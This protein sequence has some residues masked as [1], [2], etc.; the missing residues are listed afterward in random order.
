MNNIERRKLRIDKYIDR[1][2][3]KNDSGLWKLW[4]EVY[5]KRQIIFFG[6]TL[7][8]IRIGF[9]FYSTVLDKFVW[10]MVLQIEEVLFLVH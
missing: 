10:K 9:I 2:E 4:V 3:P 8:T 6:V 5:K 7:R 1:L